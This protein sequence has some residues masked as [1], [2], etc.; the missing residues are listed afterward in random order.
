MGIHP[1]SASKPRN[2]LTK[3]K[4][5][6]NHFG[7]VRTPSSLPL[8]LRYSDKSCATTRGLSA[9]ILDPKPGLRPII[10]AQRVVPNPY[11][12][13]G[14]ASGQFVLRSPSCTAV[15]STSNNSGRGSDSLGLGGRQDADLCL[16]RRLITWRHLRFEQNPRVVKLTS[17]KR[18]D[19]DAPNQTTTTRASPSWTGRMVLPPPPRIDPIM[20]QEPRRSGSSILGRMAFNCPSAQ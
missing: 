4:P 12:R 19:C 5:D 3:R 9:I 20:V 6:P 15:V 13:F 18:R 16:A 8:P 14:Q 10:D 11:L 1:N 17:K 7:Q 2:K